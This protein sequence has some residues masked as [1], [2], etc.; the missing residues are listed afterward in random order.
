[1]LAG[2]VD[3]IK[4]AI[5]HSQTIDEMIQELPEQLFASANDLLLKI[6]HIVSEI[7]GVNPDDFDELTHF[8]ELGFDD[9]QLFSL[10][11]RIQKELDNNI[12]ITLF[13]ATSTIK[14]LV[15]NLDKNNASSS[16][17]PKIKP[18]EPSANY[19]SQLLRQIF[20]E[21]LKLDIEQ[22]NGMTSFAELG[23]NSILLMQIFSRLEEATND[24]IPREVLLNAQN[25]DEVVQYL[26][27]KLATV[28]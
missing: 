17:S 2:N 15:A 16:F 5:P 24:S 14:T 12:S 4:Q 27:N 8:S 13:K 1:M 18:D 11:N 10:Y 21:T 25:I 6:K 7:V 26:E 9:M 20:S 3:K 23:L 22:I 19:F 28:K